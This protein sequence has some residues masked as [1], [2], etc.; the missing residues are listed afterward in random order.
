M[1][2]KSRRPDGHGGWYVD[3]L[4]NLKKGDKVYCSFYG[5]RYIPTVVTR[6]R[7]VEHATIVTVE[8]REG[9]YCN[10]FVGYRTCNY[11]TSDYNGVLT[12]RENSAE[13][14]ERALKSAS[15][16]SMVIAKRAD[17]LNALRILKAWLSQPEDEYEDREVE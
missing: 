15:E 14:A 5:E 13:W 12:F 6:V 9:M 1:G 10:H 11:A 4:K 2:K 7:T 8:K 17:A 16:R 3:G